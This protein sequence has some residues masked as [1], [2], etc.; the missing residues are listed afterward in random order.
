MDRQLAELAEIQHGVVTRAQLVSLGLTGAAVDS[1]LRRGSLRL[2]HRGVYAVGHAALRDEGFWLAAVLACGPRAVLSHL[3]AGCLWRMRV[4]RDPQ[5]H[6]TATRRSGPAGVVV[7]ETRHLSPADI[8]IEHGIRV[9]TPARTVIDC[10]DLLTFA[11]LRV[12]ADHGVRLDVA[13]LRRAQQRAPT[14]AGAGR[15]ARLL[16]D[17]VRTRSGLERRLRKLCCDA[18]LP[19]P[20]INE[21]VSG[22]ERDAVWPGHRLVVEVDGGAFHAPKPAREADYERD[23]ALVAAGWRV[24]RFTYDQVTYEPAQVAARLSALTQ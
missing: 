14:R 20:R 11:E 3:S 12:L 10:A 21:R 9:T 17:D 15:V 6:V 7:H 18:R 2:V 5:V 16:G 8:T 24:V 13:A 4:R 19:S 23:A 22:H 1:R